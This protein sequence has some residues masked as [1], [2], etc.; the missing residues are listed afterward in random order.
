M[1]LKITKSFITVPIGLYIFIVSPIVNADGFY[2]I[3]G[4]DGFP[5]V[6]PQSVHDRKIVKQPKKSKPQEAT[7]L[8]EPAKTVEEKPQERKEII[9][10]NSN[11]EII[12]PKQR[13]PAESKPVIISS[14]PEV[15]V[16]ESEVV[17][18]V[19]KVI[20]SGL[21]AEANKS[22][23]IQEESVLAKKPRSIRQ[24]FKKDKKIQEATEAVISSSE[25]Q[26]DNEQKLN[27][28][29]TQSKKSV[30][31]ESQNKNFTELDGVKYVDSEFLEDSEFNLEGRKRFYIMPDAP[32]AGARHVETVERQKGVTKSILEKFTKA[33]EPE[34]V[35]VM[36][37]SSTYY[38]LPKDQ[39]EKAL[40][41]S[42]FT[43]K[44]IKKAKE[45]SQKNTQLGIWPTAPI[46]ER[47]MY[48]V[49]K[50]NADINN[51][52]LTSYASSLKNPEYYWPLA[53]FLDQN[54]CVVE[55]VSGFKS[56]EKQESP[57]EH[58]ALTGLLKKPA[59]AQYLFLTPLSTAIDVENK[60]LTNQGQIKLDVIR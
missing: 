18:K 17:P 29:D 25:V 56:Q 22:T 49:V 43:G 4:P 42:C 33:N 23:E 53:V 57:L 58:A 20:P 44:K 48:E 37:L 1:N 14:K 24:L 28:T 2:T 19:K 5:M 3:I 51:I 21:P 59:Q 10:K 16:V 35:T 36:A 50:L 54:G 6:V 39:V 11:L 60:Q 31:L 47:F 9:S 27:P 52:Q 15:E 13:V 32:T 8:V 26:I 30:E 12:T 7:K 40:E 45:L 46:K 34:N 38:R 55:G 41:Q